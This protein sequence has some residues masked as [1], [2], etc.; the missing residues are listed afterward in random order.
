M[1]DT[2]PVQ[3]DFERA[4]KLHPLTSERRRI[5]AEEFAA[6]RLAAI[7]EAANA[8]V[9]YCRDMNARH[10]ECSFT[11]AVRAIRKLGETA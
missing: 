10:K 9:A 2:T 8:V 5:I 7:E 1:S 4:D 3:A 11:D 6:H